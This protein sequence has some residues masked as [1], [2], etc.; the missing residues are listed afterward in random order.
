M[1]KAADYVDN[2]NDIMHTAS[3]MVTDPLGATAQIVGGRIIGHG[4]NVISNK[5]HAKGGTIGSSTKID[6]PSSGGKELNLSKAISPDI[7]ADLDGNLSS[8][9][10][11]LTKKV[12]RD[13]PIS[14]H[15]DLHRTSKPA[16]IEFHTA[17][18]VEFEQTKLPEVSVTNQKSDISQV[19]SQASEF[20]KSGSS[21]VEK[22][23]LGELNLSKSTDTEIVGERSVEVSVS[24]K[25]SKEIEIDSRPDSRAIHSSDSIEVQKH[26]EMDLDSQTTIQADVVEATVSAR[27]VSSTTHSPDLDVPKAGQVDVK[28]DINREVPKSR[29]VEAERTKSG[30]GMDD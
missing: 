9:K 5:I 20:K 2:A 29:E 18:Q 14:T 15:P 21:T 17:K 1:T 28:P 11:D 27:A 4:A 10:L 30:I 13:L 6:Q 3:D 22:A 12:D 8:S 26:T 7:K 24:S 25:N 23:D 19:S 16:D